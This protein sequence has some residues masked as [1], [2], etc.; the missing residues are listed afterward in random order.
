[1]TAPHWIRSRQAPLNPTT[2]GSPTTPGADGSGGGH[3][4]SDDRRTLDWI[5]RVVRG[6]THRRQGAAAREHDQGRRK[7]S[8]RRVD[9][10]GGLADFPGGYGTIHDADEADRL[11]GRPSEITG[12]TRAPLELNCLRRSSRA[13]EDAGRQIASLLG[14]YSAVVVI[15][16]DPVAAAHVALGIARAEASTDAQSS[17]IW[18]AT[19]PSLRSLV[20]EEIRTASPTAFSYGVSLNKIGYAVEGNEIS[21]SCP[22]ERIH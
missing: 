9:E 3:C 4:S 14:I 22:A 19:S 7:P 21:T 10:H 11:G 13:W 6:A 12:S 20:T 8:A 2:P 17:E 1:M 15:S 18:S 16:S 5:Y